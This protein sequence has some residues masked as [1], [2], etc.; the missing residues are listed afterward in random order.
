MTTALMERVDGRTALRSLLGTWSTELTTR[1]S[2]ALD[3]AR[4]TLAAGAEVFIAALPNDTPDM[5]VAAAARLRAAG[6]TPVPHIVARR[7][8]DLAAFDALLAR[9]EAEAGIDRALVLGGDRDRPVGPFHSALQLIETGLL[10]RRGVRRIFVSCYPEGHPRIPDEVLDDARA[11]K[12]RAAEAS[13]LHATLL[14]QFCF[15]PGPILALAERMRAL[16]QTAPFRVGVAGPARRATL[17]RYALTCGIGPSLRALKARGELAR[18]MLAAE[19]P[20]T[21]LAALAAAQAG[22]PALGLEGA[23]FFTF[24][25]LARSAEF[26]RDLLA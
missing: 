9:L 23:H 4:R 5:T 22:R 2:K 21:L 6:L 19:T 14:S 26:A 8:P 20:G 11:A 3:D 25:G 12:L 10:Q 7:L 18:T 17:A 16:G 1:D 24:G 15:A 13:G